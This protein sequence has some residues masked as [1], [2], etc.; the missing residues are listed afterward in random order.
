MRVNYSS[1]E[2]DF[3][4]SLV[5]DYGLDYRCCAICGQN[6]SAFWEHICLEEVRN[7]LLFIENQYNDLYETSGCHT[8]ANI[9]IKYRHKLLDRHRNDILVSQTLD[10]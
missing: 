4:E 5:G 10:K 7:R 3:D 9:S 6:I 2:T 1:H 8:S